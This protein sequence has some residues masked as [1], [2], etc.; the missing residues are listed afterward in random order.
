[1]QQVP[2]SEK[3]IRMLFKASENNKEIK[4]KNNSIT[5]YYTEEVREQNG[6]KK[7]EDINIGDVILTNKGSRKISKII[8]NNN[9]YKLIFS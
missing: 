2:S 9:T 4:V 3:S 5:I 6:W 8:I 1:M 7:A